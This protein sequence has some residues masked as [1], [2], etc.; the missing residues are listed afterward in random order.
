MWPP[1]KPHSLSSYLA[2]LAP[3]SKFI[4]QL[5]H[6]PSWIMGNLLSQKYRLCSH[7]LSPQTSPFASVSF[8]SLIY[9]PIPLLCKHMILL[10]KSFRC[11]I[12]K[13]QDNIFHMIRSGTWSLLSKVSCFFSFLFFFSSVFN[14]RRW[15]C[16][17]LQHGTE[18]NL[19][20]DILPKICG[21]ISIVCKTV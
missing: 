18:M 4:S 7:P 19:N 2:S 13:F 11:F 8:I 12:S 10:P 16:I 6:L 20:G 17:V 15:N 9:L 5:S 1:S 3:P 14:N 21:H